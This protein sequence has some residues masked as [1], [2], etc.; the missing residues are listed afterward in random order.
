MQKELDEAQQIATDQQV[1]MDNCVK[2]EGEHLQF[3]QKIS[4]KN[5][6]LQSE[7]SALNTKVRVLCVYQ[8]TKYIFTK[9]IYY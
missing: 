8:T 7:N 4:D 5:A 6:R 1:D 3:T 9:N 2:R